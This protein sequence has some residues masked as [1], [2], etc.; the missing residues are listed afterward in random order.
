V[1][2]TADR[3]IEPDKVAVAIEH[4]LTSRRPH[5]RYLV[6]ADARAQ[7]LGRRLLP[8]RAFDRLVARVMGI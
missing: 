3:G 4:A 7:A 1:K 2:R 8:D 6:G 5:T